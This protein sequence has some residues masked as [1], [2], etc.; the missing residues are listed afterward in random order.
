L[1]HIS[2]IGK[3]FVK[4]LAAHYSPGQSVTVRV[5]SVDRD[6]N[7][8]NLSMKPELLVADDEDE[9]AADDVT[10][11]ANRQPGASRKSAATVND[12]DDE[13]VQAAELEDSSSEEADG[14]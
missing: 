13:M 7:K 14:R 10:L 11:A 6:N 5:L 9:E 1:V 4:D 2:Q 12:M 3:G 8:V